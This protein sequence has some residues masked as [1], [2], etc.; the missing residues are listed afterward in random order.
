[1]YVGKKAEIYTLS[2]LSPNLARSSL[3]C[4]ISSSS[5]VNFLSSP[6]PE[7]PFFFSLLDLEEDD[8]F[9]LSLSERDED[10][11]SDRLLFSLSLSFPDECLEGGER[12]RERLLL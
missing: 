3:A 8:D 9:D 10:D 11:F 7:L 12:L 5:A 4:L 6:L 1:M 2:G